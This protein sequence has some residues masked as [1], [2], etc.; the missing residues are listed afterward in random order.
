MD[1]KEVFVYYD[2]VLTFF[3]VSL[4]SIKKS[5]QEYSAKN[6]TYVR[7]RLNLTNSQKHARFLK[8]RMF[9]K[10]LLDELVE[11]FQR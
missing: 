4:Q 8:L 1:L 7:F 9:V 2:N 10:E 5:A 6:W 11:I 3:F